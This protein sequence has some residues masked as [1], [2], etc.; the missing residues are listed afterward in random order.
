MIEFILHW[1]RAHRRPIL[2]GI[3]SGA[4]WGFLTAAGATPRAFLTYDEA[5]GLVLIERP[6]V[7]PITISA[8]IFFQAYTA[9][10]VRVTLTFLL[11]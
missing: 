8:D 1:T 9:N 2:W 7:A 6:G 10:L 4:L 3:L 5:Q 11:P